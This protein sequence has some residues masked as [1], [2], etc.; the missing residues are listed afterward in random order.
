MGSRNGPYNADFP[1]GTTVRIPERAALEKFRAT[2]K[3]HHPLQ[4]EQLDYAGT[5]TAVTEVGF[6]HGGDELYSLK[7]V[8]GLW[9]GDLLS[10]SE[11]QRDV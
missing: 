4:D 3:W 6:Y 7:G 8:P 10:V 11:T 5:T 9:H 2:W 1:V